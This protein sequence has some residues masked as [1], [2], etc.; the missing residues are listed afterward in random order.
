MPGIEKVEQRSRPAEPQQLQSSSPEGPK[1][2]HSLGAQGFG[3]CEVS[4]S[5]TRESSSARAGSRARFG[6]L[7]SRAL[8]HAFSRARMTVNLSSCEKHR[9]GSRRE[10]PRRRHPNRSEANRQA[11]SAGRQTDTPDHGCAIDAA[12]HAVDHDRSR[13]QIAA[14]RGPPPPAGDKHAV[15]GRLQGASTL[16]EN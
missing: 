5:S 12:R 9:A 13:T 11:R 8:P 10:P 1:P 3:K 16:R 7:C 15:G 14:R 6:D 4:L 2:P